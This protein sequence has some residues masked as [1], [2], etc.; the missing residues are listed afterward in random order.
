LPRV[1]AR[2]HAD[3]L[4][5]HGGPIVARERAQPVHRRVLHPRPDLERGE[6]G[7]RVAISVADDALEGARE[8]LDLRGGPPEEAVAERQDPGRLAGRPRAADP[9]IAEV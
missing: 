8:P 2:E 5:L 1:A 9:A 7:R 3:R 4:L 6:H